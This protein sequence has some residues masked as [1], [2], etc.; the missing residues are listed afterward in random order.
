MGRQAGGVAP[1]RDAR[2]LGV[3]PAAVPYVGAD[4]TSATLGSDRGVTSQSAWVD[5][6]RVAFAEALGRGQPDLYVR[7]AH[8]TQWSGLLSDLQA[9]THDVAAIG[10][11][12]ARKGTYP[13]PS[14]LD[15]TA[16]LFSS[17]RLVAGV[18]K[19]MDRLYAQLVA[20]SVTFVKGPPEDSQA[21]QAWAQLLTKGE[22]STEGLW[23][24]AW[25]RMAP[26]THTS[27]HADFHCAYCS[28]PYKGWGDHMVCSCPVVL[29]AALTGF[30]DVCAL[31]RS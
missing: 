22:V 18:P 20:L 26:S 6:V 25:V 16:H 12:M 2:S 4:C 1:R 27:A 14:T 5:K 31:L 29:A 15:G 9:R 7:A 24:A 3:A 13:L 21:L 19:E 28:Q 30:G 23:L 8:N 10:L 11:G 17:R